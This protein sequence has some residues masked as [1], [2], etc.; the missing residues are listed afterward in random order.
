MDKYKFVEALKRFAQ[1]N[2]AVVRLNLINSNGSPMDGAKLESLN[3]NLLRDCRIASAVVIP[4]S[5]VEEETI[6]DSEEGD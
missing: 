3:E 5:I 4:I 1:D 2:G 6:V